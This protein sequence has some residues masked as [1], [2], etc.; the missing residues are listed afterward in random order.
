[1]MLS[2]LELLQVTL[3]DQRNEK[4]FDFAQLKIL[5][6]WKIESICVEYALDDPTIKKATSG[7][8]LFFQ[9][10]KEGLEW[11]Y[12]LELQL[13]EPHPKSIVTCKNI[14]KAFWNLTC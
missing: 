6:S 12:H 7:L 4:T 10:R 13:L 1:M 9:R 11:R 8:D 3:R 5:R 14:A 2:T